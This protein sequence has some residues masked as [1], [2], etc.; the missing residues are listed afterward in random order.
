MSADAAQPSVL[1]VEDDSKIAALL[2]DY[3]C[4]AAFAVTVEG[5]GRRAVQRV[6]NAAPDAVILDL[7]LPGLDGIEVCRAV[8]G[9]SVVPIL[10][11]TAKVEE[12]DR[13]IGLDA[14]ADDYICKPF[15]P[16]EVIAR[17]QAQIRRASGALSAAA[18][19]LYSVDEAAQRITW[20]GQALALTSVEYRLFRSFLRR[21]GMV[22]ARAQLLDI[23]HADFRDVGDRVIDTH[24]KNLRRKIAAVDAESTCIAAVYGAGYRFDPPDL[25]GT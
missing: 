12:I 3:L 20:R 15:S 1:V 25:S 4:A 24:I 8:R 7:M 21:P 13:L 9:F 16:R 6:R 14:G 5:D 22:F 19:A 17:V 10:M 23:M 2:R 18:A 11:L